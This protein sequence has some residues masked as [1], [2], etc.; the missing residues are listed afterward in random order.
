ME[1]VSP[2]AWPLQAGQRL[3]EGSAERKCSWLSVTEEQHLLTSFPPTPTRIPLETLSPQPPTLPPAAFSNSKELLG[4]GVTQDG[5]EDARAYS[6][7]TLPSLPARGQRGLVRL[8]SFPGSI[9]TCCL[10]PADPSQAGQLSSQR[11]RELQEPQATQPPTSH[12]QQR[13]VPRHW[14]CPELA[15]TPFPTLS[16]EDSRKK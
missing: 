15:R 12:A 10:S 13:H 1:T 5:E 16:Q 14:P 4:Q 3:R 2:L 8:A 9:F 7:S 6:P 11:T